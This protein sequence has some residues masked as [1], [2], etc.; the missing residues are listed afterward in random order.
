MRQRHEK[1][2]H[3]PDD[4]TRFFPDRRQECL[5]EAQSIVPDK[6]TYKQWN[7]VSSSEI[8][9]PLGQTYVFGQ[10]RHSCVQTGL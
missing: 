3:F 1:V 5:P 4:I 2:E 6:T 7:P 9:E 8:H 10:V